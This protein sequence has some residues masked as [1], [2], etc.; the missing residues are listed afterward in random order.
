MTYLYVM[1]PGDLGRSEQ[2][3]DCERIRARL[4]RIYRGAGRA[5]CSETQADEPLGVATA[6]SCLLGYA[7]AAARSRRDQRFGGRCGRWPSR[8]STPLA[9]GLLLESLWILGDWERDDRIRAVRDTRR[10]AVY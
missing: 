5:A 8:V 7:P 1:N 9:T 10:F 3:I 2:W 6:S 4:A